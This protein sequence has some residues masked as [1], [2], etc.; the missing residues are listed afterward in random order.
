MCVWR[1]ASLLDEESVVTCSYM[2]I[3]APRPL[4]FEAVPGGVTIAARGGGRG[5]ATVA[6]RDLWGQ[7][8]SPHTAEVVRDDVS[9]KD[10]VS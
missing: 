9:H 2:C 5:D 7:H 4:D 8:F 3:C 10:M 6:R 1:S